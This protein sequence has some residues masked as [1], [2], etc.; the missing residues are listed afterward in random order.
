MA[1]GL[2]ASLCGGQRARQPHAT[3]DSSTADD[4][5]T[6]R[7]SPRG[8]IGKRKDIPRWGRQR[9][10]RSAPMGLRAPLANAPMAPHPRRTHSRA[11]VRTAAMQGSGARLGSHGPRRHGDC[12]DVARARV[13]RGV[14]SGRLTLCE[15]AGEAGQHV[16]GGCSWRVGRGHGKRLGRGK[17]GWGKA[18]VDDRQL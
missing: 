8:R 17:L 1:F 6:A 13:R 11:A 10:R 14:G 3:A 7:I 12:A 16:G 2:A 15:R 18:A 9:A 5:P 4:S